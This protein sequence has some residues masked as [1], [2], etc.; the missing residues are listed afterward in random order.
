M[1]AVAGIVLTTVS[2]ACCAARERSRLVESQSLL[3]P[4]TET[5]IIT[6]PKALEL[7]EEEDTISA[8]ST[9]ARKQSKLL[10]PH[11]PLSSSSS[12][13]L[14]DSNVDSPPANKPPTL[15]EKWTQ[16]RTK[17]RQNDVSKRRNLNN[18]V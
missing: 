16:E 9:P 2:L 5:N 4:A 18:L 3:A 7:E 12:R 8:V 14:A 1:I 6:R 13:R 15:Q 11:T 17:C 10:R